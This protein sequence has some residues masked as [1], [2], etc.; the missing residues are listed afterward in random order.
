[1]HNLKF[2]P[3][4]DTPDQLRNLKKEDLP[5]VCRELRDYLIFMV[6]KMGGHLA[7]SLG[8]VE[9]VVASHYVFNTPAD[10][11]IWDVGHQAYG[12]KIITGR[13]DKFHTLRQYEGLSGFLRREESPYDVFNAGHAGTSVSAGLGM[14][15]ARDLTKRDFK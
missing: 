11:V 3:F 14:A 2:L 15:A 12:H 8:A 10:K 7:S 6:S 4:I 13:R 1:M 9:L 5:A